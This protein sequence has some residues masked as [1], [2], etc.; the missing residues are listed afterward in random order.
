MNDLL[1]LCRCEVV[2]GIRFERLLLIVALL[3]I[4]DMQDL[5]IFVVVICSDMGVDV[6]H[7][8]E[9]SASVTGC[10]LVVRKS[11]QE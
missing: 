9:A 8:G 7:I 5:L 4:F 11:R 6:R 10:R 1:L 2:E 3:A